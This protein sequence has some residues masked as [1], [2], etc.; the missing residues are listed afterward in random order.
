MVS[1]HNIEK[2]RGPLICGLGVGG[3]IDALEALHRS[4]FTSTPTVDGGFYGTPYSRAELLE[5]IAVGAVVTAKTGSELVGYGILDASSMNSNSVKAWNALDR[6]MLADDLP[7]GRY[8]GRFSAAVSKTWQG[9][10]AYR[11]ILRNAMRLGRGRF[12]YFFGVVDTD[13]P[14]RA[15][16]SA[17]GWQEVGQ[18]GNISY[19]VLPL[20]GRQP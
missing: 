3:D 14:K 18:D 13:H 9:K 10:G 6:L 15:L 5:L 16:Q 8:C 1:G 2:S 20:T 19:L 17:L 12:D 11:E 4:W 7:E